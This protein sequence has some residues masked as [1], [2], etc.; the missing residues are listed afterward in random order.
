MELLGA[1]DQPNIL[2]KALCLSVTFGAPGSSRQIST[3]DVDIKPKTPVDLKISDKEANKQFIN[4]TKKLFISDAYKLACAVQGKVKAY[5]KKRALHFPLKSGVYLIPTAFLEEVDNTM[6]AFQE[7]FKA[8]AHAFAHDDYMLA[9]DRAKNELG[10]FYDESQYFDTAEEVESLFI[11]ELKYVTFGTPEKLKEIS[12]T[13]WQRAIDEMKNSVA[14][15]TNSIQNDIRGKMAELLSHAFEKLSN[16]AEGKRKKFKDASINNIKQFIKEFK[17]LNITD[18]SALEAL[19][20][21]ANS[22][23]EGV[24]PEFLRTDDGLRQD[25]CTKFNGLMGELD[26]MIETSGG[27]KFQKI[28]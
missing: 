24:S 22:L 28:A 18:D 11:F 7:E 17:D 12:P 26:S 21:K 14:A 2:D 20:Q 8:L 1:S 5:L 15:A 19:V 13:I 9:R 25:I 10:P 4:I 27:R 6:L 23:I 16:D 3:D